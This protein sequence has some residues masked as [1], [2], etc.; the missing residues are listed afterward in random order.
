MRMIPERNDLGSDHVI[1]W[2][3]DNYDGTRVTGTNKNSTEKVWSL[4]IKNQD[5]PLVKLTNKNR[6]PIL[7]SHD[8]GQW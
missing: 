6:S 4:H 2:R 3:Y 7:C 1:I 5:L 8:N